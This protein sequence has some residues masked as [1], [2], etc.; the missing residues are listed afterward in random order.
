MGRK[1]KTRRVQVRLDPT[2]EIEGKPWGVVIVE[3]YLANQWVCED[4][5][6]LAEEAPLVAS[7]VEADGVQDDALVVFVDL[8]RRREGVFSG[9]GAEQLFEVEGAK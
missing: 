1:R 4:R 5:R 7:E 3:N 2:E 9:E 6:V 8:R